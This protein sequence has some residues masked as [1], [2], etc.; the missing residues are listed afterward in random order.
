MPALTNSLSA[1]GNFQAVR[2]ND[3]LQQDWKIRQVSGGDWSDPSSWT[4]SG[5]P[6]IRIRSGKVEKVEQKGGMANWSASV[7]VGHVPVT[8]K[9]GFKYQRITYKFD[10]TSDNYLYTYAGPLSNAEFLKTIQSSNQI[11]TAKTGYRITTSSASND[12][13]LPSMTK[14]A[15]MYKEN[16]GQWKHTL[17]A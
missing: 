4:L 7:G 16:P 10:D 1:R 12:I 5:T 17:S 11:S 2:S 14:L 3:P 9:T 8:F 15:E 13:Y 6:A